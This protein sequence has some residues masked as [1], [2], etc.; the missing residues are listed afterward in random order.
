MRKKGKEGGR[1]GRREGGDNV[2]FYNGPDML[3]AVFNWIKNI[4]G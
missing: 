1:K 2:V 4:Q 3:H